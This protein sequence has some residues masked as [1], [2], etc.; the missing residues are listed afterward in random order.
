MTAP[1]AK[2]I[3]YQHE[4]HHEVRQD[5]YYWMRDREN[6]EVIAHLEA[7]N[8]Y[9]KA[10]LAHTEDL[11]KELFEEIKARIK[12]EDQ[13]V[14]Y[15]WRGY[16]YYSRFETGKEYPIYARKKGSLEAEEEI[17]LDVNV[18]AE[19]QSYCQSTGPAISPK[20]DLIA[21]GIDLVGRRIYEI[22]FFNL[23][24]QTYYEERIPDVTGN[25][26]WAEDNR[27]IFYSKQDP[28]TL[29]SHQ[30]YRHTLGTD[31]AEDVLIYEEK[32][33]TFRTY[34]SKTRSREYL[35]ILSTSTLSD[36]V[37][38]LAADQP[39][40]EWQMFQTREREHEYGIDHFNGTFYIL[41]NWE[42]VNFRLMECPS[43]GDQTEKS[44]W[45]SLIPH[46]KDTLLEDFQ[47]FR[48]HLVV[49]ERTNG[50]NQIRVMKWADKQAWY[51]EYQDPAYS[52]SLGHNPDVDTPNLRYSYESL[53]TPR[54]TFEINFETKETTLLK[55]QAVLGGFE[56][57]N[58][59][60]ERLFAT[61][62]DGTQVPMSIVY[63]KGTRDQ[64][65]APLLLYAYGSYGYS[66]DPY[67]SL[68]RLSLLD[69]G[70]IYVIAHIRGG[71]EMGRFWYDEGKLL[72]KKNTFT[73][74]IACAEH[75]LESGY[76]EGEKLFIS[77]GSAGGLLVGA[78][79][80]MRPK[81]FYGAI[82][83][84]PFVDVVSTMLDEDI[85]LTTGEFDEW[86]NPKDKTYYDYML[87]YS[88]YDNVVA[89]DYPHLL[90]TSGLHDSQVQYWEPTK[91]VARLRE[92]KTG[93]QKLLLHTNMDAGHSGASGR[94]QPYIEVAMEYAFLLDL[95]GKG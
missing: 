70:F 56:V 20:Q 15:W 65:S 27:T 10:Q 50:L 33:D 40:G 94:Y 26:V 67:F 93:E 57:E 18:L 66:L 64:G 71:E 8:A 81:L 76:T 80:N 52:A 2:Q 38:Y 73:D 37:R 34:V 79:I 88:P 25:I 3:P 86:G 84:V 53:T 16:Y 24:T 61:A 17:T 45:K 55:Q 43:K 11:Q 19:G 58:Y 60:S 7:E 32:D 83:A 72:K 90:V 51:I 92:L 29:R 59:Q 4:I 1:V 91:W 85:P 62:S 87:S 30:I 46:S 31:P 42:A 35:L 36:E 6:P 28:Q 75:L 82:A 39:E 54:S 12:E 48:D 9:T 21:F 47:L 23:E 63:R 22:R 68:A 44:N 41:T 78:V 69:R 95:A 5:P 74:F 89:Q 13:S 77:G 14:P 49:E